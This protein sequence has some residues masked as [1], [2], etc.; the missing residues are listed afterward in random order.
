M[1]C[2]LGLVNSN[3]GEWTCRMNWEGF[4]QL[5]LKKISSFLHLNSLNSYNMIF[6]FFMNHTTVVGEIS[7]TFFQHDSKPF[8][9]KWTP[10]QGQRST[11]E[12][13]P[14]AHDGFT[15]FSGYGRSWKILRW[16]IFC[17]PLRWNNT[18]LGGGGDF[19][20]SGG[21]FCVY[22]VD[23]WKILH[24]LRLV[25]WPIIYRA[26]YIPG[27]DRWISSINSRSNT[28][29][30]PKH[31]QRLDSWNQRTNCAIFEGNFTTSALDILILQRTK[32]IVKWNKSSGFSMPSDYPLVN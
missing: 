32:N 6:N 22:A 25:V 12:S 17:F 20:F 31:H 28:S 14:T 23:A 30:V 27:G 1:T 4:S 29:K 24:Q 18:S 3:C 2:F 10:Q 16:R 13:L 8:R 11:N 19:F 9:M 21:A 26:L 15:I 7:W 5:K